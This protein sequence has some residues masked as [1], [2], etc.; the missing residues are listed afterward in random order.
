MKK[1]I[2]KNY[3]FKAA[4][5]FIVLGLL[6][7]FSPALADSHYII[8][9]NYYAL[10]GQTIKVTG[11]GFTPTETINVS[12]AGMEKVATAD[13]AGSFT[14]TAFVIPFSAI[15]STQTVS[16]T[17]SLGHSSSAN[18][19]VGTFYPNV[20]PSSWYVAPGGNINF[21][22]VG[23]APNEDVAIIG[24]GKSIIA[25][26]GGNGNFNSSNISIPYAPPGDHTFTF[27]GKTSGVV[28]NITVSIANEPAYLVLNN[29]VGS[30]GTPLQING[31]AFGVA[32]DVNVAYQGIPLG[33]IAATN[34]GQFSFNT[35]VITSDALGPK[36]II[37]VGTQTGKTAQAIFTLSNYNPQR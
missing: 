26:T 19:V 2:F 6:A 7:G 12:L 22:G 17:G 5:F 16:A 4:G 11:N 3:L 32:E 31:S 1:N 9:S 15:N 18:L 30:S 27:T 21:S 20:T 10:P 36:T 37:A 33:S 34:T 29:Y 28:R 23:F 24:M 8:L 35:Q 25:T 14:T 13:L